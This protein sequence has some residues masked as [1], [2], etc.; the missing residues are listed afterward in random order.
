MDYNNL[1]LIT[2]NIYVTQDFYDFLTGISIIHVKNKEENDSLLEDIKDFYRANKVDENEIN[3]MF[4]SCFH[5][6]DENYKY[7][8][9]EKND[10]VRYSNEYSKLIKKYDT[11]REYSDCTFKTIVNENLKQKENED[12]LEKE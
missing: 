1:H 11:F 3:S 4:L 6:Y 5:D 8:V 12:E 10:I 7:F 9:R 2:P